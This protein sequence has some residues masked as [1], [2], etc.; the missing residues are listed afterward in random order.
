[1]N[2]RKLQSAIKQQKFI[3]SKWS[4]KSYS[5]FQVL[6]KVVVIACL[7]VVYHLTADANEQVIFQDT[8]LKISKEV[9]FDEIEVRVQ[10]APVILSQAAR[11]VSV[12]NS[13]EIKAAPVESIQE[14]LSYIQSVDVRQ[15]GGEGVQADI[16]IRGG[17]FDQVMILLNGIDITDPQTGHH[18]LNIPVSLQQI[19]RIEIIKGPASRIFGPN[20]FSGAINI[21]TEGNFENKL[22]ANITKGSYGYFN[23]GLSGSVKTGKISQYFAV[24]YKTSDGYIEN[25]DFKTQ[26]LYYKLTA[27]KANKLTFQL[28]LTNK[29][30]G[31]NSFYTPKFPEQFEKVKTFFS[32]V[33][34]ESNTRLHLTPA[35]YWRRL[36]DKFELFRNEAPGWYKSHN[37]HLTDVYGI[38]LNTW[39]LSKFGKT[40]FG[41]N[42]RGNKIL[43][44][45]LGVDINNPVDVRGEDAQYSKSDTRNTYSVFLEQSYYTKNWV[46]SAGV[47]ANRI[48]DSNAGINF[49]PGI[50]IACNLTENLR[51]YSTVNKSLRMPT[52]TDLY[53]ND[54]TNVG[55]PGL[56]PE[57][58]V[59]VEGGLKYKSHFIKSNLSVFYRNGKNIIDWVRLG[60]ET[61]WH[62]ENLTNIVSTGVEFD[63]EYY[64]QKQFGE[65]FIISK[66]R[67]GYLYN[68]LEKSSTN[69]ISNYVLNN[70]K[71]KLDISV[72]HKI[73]KNLN[74]NWVLLIQDRNGTYTEFSGG[75]FGNETEYVPFALVNG[76]LAYNM[77]FFKFYVSVSNIFNTSYFDIGNVIQPGRWVKAGIQFNLRFIR[78]M[79]R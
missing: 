2:N 26:N 44:N 71:H 9:D 6:K 48:S 62:T 73:V 57:T 56:K 8:T 10:R 69:Y 38:N 18:N 20:A 43:S 1:M 12:I 37:Y 53:Y 21:I 25:T 36:H 75:S 3:F 41:A 49:F 7:A 70:L 46:V 4:R 52:F 34:W 33:L 51:L 28:G 14:L 68:N 32:S 19:Q 60:N 77:Q 22:S 66:I 11:I 29:E 50:D 40:S 23:S 54:P 67:V 30:F 31:A 59:S 39:F 74:A 17:S 16:S 79:C 47:M 35:L 61:K 65:S 63:F 13:E 72:S 15:R 55:N 45:V 42:F 24:N 5:L 78:K 76:K 27:G 58:A 64:P